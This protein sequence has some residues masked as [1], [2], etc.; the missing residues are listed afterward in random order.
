MDLDPAALEEA[1][2]AAGTLPSDDERTDE[3]H[4]EVDGDQ[5]HHEGELGDQDPEEVEDDAMSGPSFPRDFPEAMTKAI[6]M[7]Q[8]EPEVAEVS[9]PG[10]VG[11]AYR[12]VPPR[13]KVVTLPAYPEFHEKFVQGTW[14]D[15]KMAPSTI[16]TLAPCD[17]VQG[18]KKLIE[19]GTPRVEADLADALQ[20][21]AG[22]WERRSKGK[23]LPVR[24]SDTNR[25]ATRDR[26]DRALK[27]FAQMGA[28]ASSMALI[29]DFVETTAYR[30]VVDDKRPLDM[31]ESTQLIQAMSVILQL[32]V[33]MGEAAGAGIA[34]MVYLQRLLW[35]QLGEISGSQLNRGTLL[36]APLSTESLFGPTWQQAAERQVHLAESRETLSQLIRPAGR[37]GKRP[38]NPPAKPTPQGGG[39]GGQPPAKAQAKTGYQQRRQG[40]QAGAG[41]GQAANRGGRGGR[42]G[43]K[44]RGRGGHYWGDF[45]KTPKVE[46]AAGAKK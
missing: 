26:A 6:V 14:K 28:A 23:L 24:F 18:F 27:V 37:G 21:G 12:R 10:G 36:S 33:G 5:V 43:G 38:Y 32:A 31:E 4:S 2:R 19:E 44:G 42:G 15:P 34:H 9:T 22:D 1:I 25:E 40:K 46:E 17:M 11:E 29:T 41:R 35:V 30:A 20:P 8:L 39:S 3:E 16:K 7:F 45:K 13:K